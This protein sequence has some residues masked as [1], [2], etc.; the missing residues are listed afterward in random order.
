VVVVVGGRVVVVVGGRVVMV[1]G[2]RVVVVVVGGRVVVVVGDS[3][4][5]ATAVVDVV[6]VVGR[7]GGGVDSGVRNGDLPRWRPKPD[8]LRSE[9]NS[10]KTAAVEFRRQSLVAPFSEI[11]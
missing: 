1:V 2:G 4:A 3:T 5:V 11:E 7:A 9:R 10:S 6:G 8:N